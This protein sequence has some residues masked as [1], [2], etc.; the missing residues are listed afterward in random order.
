MKMRIKSLL[1][2]QRTM[3]YWLVGTTSNCI[4]SGRQTRGHEQSNEGTSCTHQYAGSSDVNISTTLHYDTMLW[5][6]KALSLCELIDGI[7]FCVSFVVPST[8]VSRHGRT[9]SYFILFTL[10]SVYP[11]HGGGNAEYKQYLEMTSLSPLP[12]SATSTKWI[13]YVNK[14]PFC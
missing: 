8:A 5:V 14:L 1:S 12:T 4:A 10:H 9:Q 11:Q 13:N 3:L 7:C 2:P 6:W